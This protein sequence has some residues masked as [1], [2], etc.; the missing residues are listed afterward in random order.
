VHDQ[1][2]YALFLSYTTSAVP[3]RE[4][5][6]PKTSGSFHTTLSSDVLGQEPQDTCILLANG[7]NYPMKSLHSPLSTTAKLCRV[8]K[9]GFIKN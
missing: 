8:D 7:L 5:P 3:I 2:T 6:T 9:G 1:E 4:P